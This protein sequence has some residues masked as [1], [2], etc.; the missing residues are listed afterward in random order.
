MINF[1]SLKV[2]LSS[3]VIVI[4]VIL[5]VVL[6]V[7]S[8]NAAYN[9]VESAYLNQLNNFNKDI[10]G[11]LHKFYQDQEENAMF[12]ADDR[13]VISAAVDENYT[14]VTDILK[15]FSEKKK[16]YQDVFLANTATIPRIVASTLPDALGISLNAEVYAE[17][18]RK[19]LG[20]ETAVSLP[21]KSNVTEKPVVLVTVPVKSGDSVV[22]LVGLSVNVGEFS[23][24]IVK[25]VTIGK[26]GY[27]FITDSNGLTY[28][29]PD[30]KQ[31][32]NLDL[33]QYEWGKKM[34]NSPSGT[35]INYLWKGDKKI[36][37][38][39]RDKKYRFLSGSTMYINDIDEDARTMAATMMIFG[40]VGIIIAVIIIYYFIASRLKPL[41]G[42]RQVMGEMAD[43][44]LTSRYEGKITGDEIGEIAGAI[45]ATMDQFEKLISEVV[46]ATQNLGQAVQEI[47]SGNE[48]L[49]QR[50]SEQASSLEE[51]AATIE[52]SNATTK[53]NADNALQANR[54]ADNA[55]KLA[56]DGGSVV[57][58]A[59]GSINE[60]NQSSK[61][62]AEIISM[63]N[64]IAFQTNLL[65][66]NAA[67]EAARAGEQGR[68][69]A[70]VAGEVRNLAQR[71]G[72]AA[73][74]INELIQDSVDKVE[75][76]TELVNK[77]GEALREIIEGIKQVN[78]IVSE[79]AA[80][81]E[82]Q[83]RG[84]DQIN[85][86]VT[87]MDTMTQQN[88]ALVEQTAS[89]SEEM[90]NQAQELLSMMDNF[91]ISNSLKKDTY[92]SKHKEVYVRAARDEEKSFASKGTGP[93]EKTVSAEKNTPKEK[94]TGDVKSTLLD[95]GFEE[96]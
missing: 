55:T 43:G 48:N 45:N 49:S 73:K 26:T 87:D 4:V 53:Q 23:R 1:K 46:V 83:R 58:D 36:L 56:E 22:A 21:F 3:I 38:F 89:A 7:S 37:T 51:I 40:I 17:D 47:A 27:P 11:Q 5:S 72:N 86:A 19:S 52:E 64:E 30:E 71:A 25:D 16:I 95:D 24:D 66:L 68:G 41:D 91:Q 31:I 29:H 2:V 57:Q 80:A 92:S 69:F 42:C 88:A 14:A 10:A 33:N 44:N 77:S 32:F 13:R 18:L 93:E 75:R 70:V 79:I 96:F 82:E 20:G 62:I 85:V 34:L 90:S 6:I 65:A 8:Y 81:S 28:A 9:S 50:T 76:G 59:V 54:Q 39:V 63:I 61:R 35:L 60:M 84:I 78:N 74:E 12:L 67:V 15:N 94:K